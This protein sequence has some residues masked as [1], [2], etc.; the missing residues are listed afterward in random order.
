MLSRV[1]D[2]CGA[3]IR[4]NTMAPSEDISVSGED[5]CSTKCALALLRS[6][7]MRNSGNYYPQMWNEMLAEA[8]FDLDSNGR[9]VITRARMDGAIA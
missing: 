1:C 9:I 3:V 8:I 2:R 5:A 4:P 7:F 6:Q